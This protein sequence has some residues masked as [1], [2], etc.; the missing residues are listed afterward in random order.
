MKKYLSVYKS[1]LKIMA[2]YIRDYK[3]YAD[4][5]YYRKK[6]KIEI[7]NILREWLFDFTM[8]L[9]KVSRL[10]TLKGIRT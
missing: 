7:L 10:V 8:E 4:N 3:R 6:K 9:K 2:D 5:S 1:K